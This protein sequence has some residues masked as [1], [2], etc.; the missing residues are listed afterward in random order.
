MK[1]HYRQVL[2][3]DGQILSNVKWSSSKNKDYYHKVYDE[4]GTLDPKVYSHQRVKVNEFVDT[5]KNFTYNREL[6]YQY[7]YE[8]YF[9]GN[10]RT[11]YARGFSNRVYSKSELKD[12]KKEAYHNFLSVISKKISGFTDE[13]LARERVQK[14]V[15]QGRAE[16]RQGIIRYS[17]I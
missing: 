2:R 3:V 12:A 11:P 16:V 6:G 15:S 7:V 9:T 10:T 8:L 13:E 1:G 14:L 4:T 17:D 5:R